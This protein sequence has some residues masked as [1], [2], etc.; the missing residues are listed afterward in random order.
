MYISD[1]WQKNR[2]QRANLPEW[3]LRCMEKNTGRELIGEAPRAAHHKAKTP[4]MHR[5]SIQ[6]AHAQLKSQKKHTDNLIKT[7]VITE[8]SA[9]IL[10]S[11]SYALI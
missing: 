11:L 7:L 1:R 4:R 9:F 3:L 6:D 2:V 8:S 10:F 5:K